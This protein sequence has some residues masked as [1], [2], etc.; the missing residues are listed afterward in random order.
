M[1]AP[2]SAC[3]PLAH[4]SCDRMRRGGVAVSPAIT[5]LFAVPAILV[6][7]TTPTTIALKSSPNPSVYGRP[8]TLTAAVTPPAAT[9][10]VTFY[11]GTAV[12]GTAKLTGGQA[13]LTTILLPFGVRSLKAYYGGDANY[14]PG[15]SAM[16]SQTVN[17]APGGGFQ[18]AVSYAVGFNPTYAAIGDFNADGKADLAVANAGSGTISVLLGNGDGTFQAAV[19]HSAGSGPVSIAVGDFNGDGKADLAVTNSGSGNVSVLLGNGDGTFQAAVNYGAGVRPSYAAIGDFNSDG[20]ADLAVANSGSGNVSVLLGNGDGTFQAAVDYGAAA[21][22]ASIAVADFNRDGKADLAVANGGPAGTVSVLLGNGDGTFQSAANFGAGTYPN[23]IAA[24]D[25]NGD[26]NVDLA[27]GNGYYNVNVLLGKGDGTFQPAA[28]YSIEGSRYVVALGDFNGD[29][30]ADIAVSNDGANNVSVLLGR[31]DGTFFPPETNYGAGTAPNSI[32]IGDF[33]GNG[34]ADIVVPNSSGNDI[35]VLLAISPFPEIFTEVSHNGNFVQGQSGA[36]YS[37]TVSNI[38]SAP[39]SGTVTVTDSLPPGLTAT[40]FSGAGWTCA[41]ATL[42]CTRE[43]PLATAASYPAIVLAVTVGVGAPGGVT[44]TV[45]VT[46]GASANINNG[47]AS[48]FTTTFTPGQ[49][50]QAWSELRPPPL[51]AGHSYGAALLMTDGTVMVN[52]SCAG[53]WYRL[54]PDSSGSYINGTWSQAASMPAGYAP[55]AFSSAVLADGRLVVIGGEYNNSG[56]GNSC[57]AVWTNLGAVYDPVA[58]AWTPLS[59]PSGWNSVGDAQNVV[60]PNGQFLLASLST[61][62]AR[63]DPATLTWTMLKG[64]GKS[65]GNDEEG[66]TLLPDGTIL[67]VDTN[68]GTHSERYLPSTDSWVSAGSTVAPLATNSEMGPQVLRPDGTVFVAGATGHTSIYNVAAGTWAAGPDFPVSNGAQL[69]NDDAP[70]SLLPSGN[71]LVTAF[72]SQSTFLFEFDGVHLNSVPLRGCMALLPLPTGQILCSGYT[73]Y[74]P[75]GTPNAAWAPTIAMAPGVVQPGQTYA[76]TGT[77]FNGLSGAVGFGDDYQGA[78]NYPLVQI[79]NT[80]TGHVFY[81]RTHHHSTMAVATGSAPVSTQFDVPPSIE[82]GPSTLVVIANGVPSK[83]WSLTVATAQSPAGPAI[84]G[85]EGSGLSVPS[86]KALSANGFFTVFG[87][88]LAPAGT[89]R[90]LAASDVVNGKLPTNL[91]STCVIAGSV[92]AF[93]TYV[94]P[95]QINGIAPP[96]PITGSAAVSVVANC[97]ASNQAASPAVNVPVAEAT[98]EFLYWVQNASGQNPVIAVDAVHGDYIGP[99]GLIPGATFRPAIPGEILTIYGIGF[100]QTA[101][102][103]VPGLI[104][105]A[106]DS[107]PSGY[108]VTIGQTTVSAGYAGVTPTDAGLYQVNVTV[109][110]GIAPGNYSI[111]LNVNGASTPTGAFLAV[112]PSSN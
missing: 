81:C 107:V 42:T 37:I 61:Q 64:T 60:L 5:L 76:I 87:T 92:P 38:G 11:D 101:S 85:V 46:G 17:A 3:A 53:N 33:N 69:F 84:Q 93:L 13:A 100:G 44:N 90:Q 25:F 105:P 58:N 10:S 56:A 55:Y 109:P 82:S 98:P 67:T 28:N 40:A 59:A 65:D 19:N 22:S 80:A 89:S 88:N 1:P 52:E 49:N 106:A 29:G 30:R 43:D 9:G 103:P 108:S 31:G 63:L 79:T 35:S 94:S 16:V 26:G 32:A 24:S 34:K 57:N 4:D 6:A 48:D 83:S 54:T 66:W 50:A 95:T 71:V 7:A 97:G 18:A 12:L 51:P 20:K 99:P 45:Q 74:T 2:L 77:Q 41:L 96:L 91:A 78:T 62:L 112:G 68:N 102:G 36:A 72:S 104:P 47:A 110:A 39:T 75:S 21:S 23:S 70:A 14:A 111:V 27:V 86:V 8:V 15:T 73:I